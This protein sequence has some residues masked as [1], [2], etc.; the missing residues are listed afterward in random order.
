MR[1]LLDRPTMGIDARHK[2][3]K[4]ETNK[5]RLS[6]YIT[7]EIKK[8]NSRSIGQSSFHSLHYMM[9]R[10]IFTVDG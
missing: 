7:G 10:Y 1:E 2:N 3:L 8:V 6:T 5:N 4:R 9:I